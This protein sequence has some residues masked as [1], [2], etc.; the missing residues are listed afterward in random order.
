MP[1]QDKGEAL[2]NEKVYKVVLSCPECGQKLRLP[3]YEDKKLRVTCPNPKCKKVF[4]FDCK[5]YRARQKLILLGTIIV[6][7]II[8]SAVIIAPIF[9]LDKGSVFIT[10]VQNEYESQFEKIQDEFTREKISIKESYNNE[11]KKIEK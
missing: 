11:I 7:F 9:L 2:N 8:L 4:S 10:K 3:I 6:C 1:Y 5:K